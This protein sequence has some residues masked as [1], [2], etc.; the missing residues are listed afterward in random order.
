TRWKLLE[1]RSTAASTSGTRCARRLMPATLAPAVASGGEGGSAAAGGLRVGIA[2]DEL[3]AL[4]A[5]AVVDF[6]AAEVL[7]AHRVDQQLHAVLFDQRV[8]VLLGL[9]EF[10]AILHAR[11]AAALH[12]D[13]QHQ[14]R[15]ALVADQF[16]HLGGRGIG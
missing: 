10:E 1:P 6:R 9:V 13:A 12:V 5:L 8:A 4:Q 2:D 7:E 15:V 11:A 14:R 16:G 3:R